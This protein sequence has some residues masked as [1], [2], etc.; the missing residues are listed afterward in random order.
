MAALATAPNELS[1]GNWRAGLPR[2]D[3]GCVLLRE[4]QPGDAASLHRISHS[5]DVSHYTW[6]APSSVEE[7]SRF[8]EWTWTERAA[9][10]YVCFG[11]VPRNS[12][13]A[14]GLFE[15][16]QMQPRFFRAEL[17]FFLDRPLWGS[18]VFNEAARL[19][20]EFAEQ[21]LRVHRI[22]ARVTVDNARSNSALH[23]L[24]AV[25]EGVLHGAFVRNGEPVDQNLWAIGPAAPLDRGC[26]SEPQG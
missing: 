17:G 20:L 9:G 25:H 23:R 13:D 2:L 22:E 15:I 5:P 3:G 10:K 8:I 21:M 4:L 19:V 26:G 16:R 14:A 1:N 18:G 6:P 12:T 11:I 24:G 7:F